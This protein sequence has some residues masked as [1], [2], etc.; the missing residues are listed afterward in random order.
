M[1]RDATD[2][3]RAV[4]PLTLAE[5]AIYLDTTAMPIDAVVE[6]VLNIVR[7]SR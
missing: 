5:G 6:L 3:T 4:A 1:V 7:A 2:S